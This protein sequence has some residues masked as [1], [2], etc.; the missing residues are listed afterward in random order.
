MFY[1]N[2]MQQDMIDTPPHLFPDD[3]PL[4]PAGR[5]FNPSEIKRYMRSFLSLGVDECVYGNPAQPGSDVGFTSIALNA[6]HCLEK[7]LL[8]E[9]IRIIRIAAEAVGKVVYVV[10]ML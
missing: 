9:I 7:R 1:W 6:P 4:L 3:F 2:M 8:H 10:L 5:T